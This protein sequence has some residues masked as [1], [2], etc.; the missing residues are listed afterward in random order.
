[1][2]RLLFLTAVLVLTANLSGCRCLDRFFRGAS[3]PPPAPTVIADPCN[4]CVPCNPCNPCQTDC[5]TCA[6]V[7]P[8]PVQYAPAG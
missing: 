8:G 1:M 3:Y 7:V 6:P 2:K 5:G 4:P